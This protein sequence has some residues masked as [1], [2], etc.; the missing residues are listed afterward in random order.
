MDREWQRQ[1]CLGV[2]WIDRPSLGFTEEAVG[3]TATGWRGEPLAS[4]ERLSGL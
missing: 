4:N 1:Q 2:M 3:G